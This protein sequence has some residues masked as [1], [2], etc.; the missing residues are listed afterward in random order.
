MKFVEHGLLFFGAQK[1]MV[2]ACLGKLDEFS[3]GESH[4]MHMAV[5]IAYRRFKH[6]WV[7]ARKRD[8]KTAPK[9]R[10]KRMLLI[11]S[12]RT[13]DLSC[14]GA[15]AKIARGA[16]LEGNVSRGDEIHG[17]LVAHHSDAV[18][19]PLGAQQFDGFADNFW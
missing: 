16:D 11:S 3:R 19:D 7:V 15:S 6:G 18:A 14:Q 8:R 2:E 12:R 13:A 1:G 5:F 10:R 17:A 9:K 4:A